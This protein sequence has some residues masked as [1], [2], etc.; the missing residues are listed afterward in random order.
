M[1]GNTLCNFA[2]CWTIQHQAIVIDREA[3]EIMHLVASVR[4]S[5]RPS[6]R[7]SVRLFVLSQLNRLTYECSKEQ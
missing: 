2:P 4:L 6:V 3:R 5:V 1:T 7:L